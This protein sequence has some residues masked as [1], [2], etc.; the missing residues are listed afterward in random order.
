MK[1]FY[2]FLTLMLLTA[3][4]HN[5]DS[6]TIEGDIQNIRQAE[7][8]IFDESQN[9]QRV[10]TILVKNGSFEITL[11]LTSPTTFT[12]L[13]PN[14]FEIPVVAHPG[15]KLSLQA[16]ATHLAQS[17]VKGNPENEALTVFRQSVAEKPLREQCLAAQQF[18]YDNVN[19]LAAV[20]VFK[21][22]FVRT[23]KPVLA[24][25]Y[26]LLDTL[27]NAQP[28]NEELAFL[29]RNYL[30]RLLCSEG[31]SLPQFEEVTI[32]G[33]S[34]SNKD[35]LG[36]PMVVTMWASWQRDIR[37]MLKEIIELE[38]TFKPQGVKFLHISLDPTLTNAK[39]TLRRDSLS[40]PVICDQ[41]CLGSPLLSTFGLR[42]IPEFILINDEGK[43]VRRDLEREQL[44]G[45]IKKLLQ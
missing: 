37:T 33:D 22:Y 25:A 2:L 41:Q 19:T 45:E 4:Q 3:C 7:L 12:L 15:D 35:Y 44:K 9:A 11:P 40:S 8:Y 38:K 20:A 43:I 18:I 5:A 28:D 13:F 23:Q 16:N 36:S 14:F 31:Q 29:Q 17:I 39:R 42:K 34:V 26:P 24:E 27:S 32:K 1:S 10:D 30:A 21:R 6:F